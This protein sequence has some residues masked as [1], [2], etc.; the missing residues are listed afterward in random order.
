VDFSQNPTG[1][2]L[3]ELVM[4][5]WSLRMMWPSIIEDMG[6]DWIRKYVALGK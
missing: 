5:M 3:K 1:E 4:V 2:L 6:H